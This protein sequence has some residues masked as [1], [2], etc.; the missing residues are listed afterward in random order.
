MQLTVEDIPDD[1]YLENSLE[2][3]R[4]PSKPKVFCRLDHYWKKI[5]A[6]TNPAGALRFVELAKLVKASCVLPHGNADAERGFSVNAR[7]VR[8]DNSSLSER[9]I[10]GLRMVKDELRSC[11]G[12][13]NVKITPSLL[14]SVEKAHS[15]FKADLERRQANEVS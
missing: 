12:V 14:N 9:S 13:L 10:R 1:W 2:L 8:K 5:F 7:T 6:L 15:E 11:G 4:D 3:S